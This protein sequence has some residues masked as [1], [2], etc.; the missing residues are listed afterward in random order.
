MTEPINNFGDYAPLIAVLGI[1]TFYVLGVWGRIFVRAGHPR[2]HALL[3]CLP[4]WGLVVAG[5]RLLEAG[6]SRWNLLW[7][8]VPFGIFGWSFYLAY[9]T[10]WPAEKQKRLLARIIG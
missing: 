1:A 7:F 10:E 3:I 8:I 9:A 2:W 4:L 5:D 6:Y